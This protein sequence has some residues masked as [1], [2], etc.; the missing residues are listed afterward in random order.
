M[1]TITLTRAEYDELIDARDHAVAMRN[2]A[3]GA[4]ETLADSELDAFLAAP[5]PLAY[6]RKRRRLS[7]TAL[8]GMAGITQPY[9]AQ[10]ERGVRTGDIWLYGRLAKA[11][12]V[13]MEDVAPID[14][15]A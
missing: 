7:Q 8:A 13:R 15:E 4:M 6:W 14:R 2:V 1:D 5:S 12:C 11:L 10:I 3:T 9:L